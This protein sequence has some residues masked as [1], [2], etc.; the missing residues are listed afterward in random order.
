MAL[1]VSQSPLWDY[2]TLHEL[3]RIW[4][5]CRVWKICW[6][7]PMYEI[8]KFGKKL[9]TSYGITFIAN[10][11]V[12]WKHL[13]REFCPNFPKSKSL[14]CSELTFW[15]P[16]ISRS[17]IHVFRTGL[18]SRWVW[19]VSRA[20]LPVGGDHLEKL[21]LLKSYLTRTIYLLLNG[22]NNLFWL[23]LGTKNAI[24]FS[25]FLRSYHR[26]QFF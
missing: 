10:S 23:W 13:F 9:Q 15:K 14:C 3:L 2:A 7:L 24:F 6:V 22:D 8:Q 5:F 11:P 16:Y 17:G 1:L 19:K 4:N 20:S 25:K 26:S 18:R 12:I 21:I